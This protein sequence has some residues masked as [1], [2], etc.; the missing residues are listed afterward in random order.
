[1]SKIKKYL[2]I[3]FL[4]ASSKVSSKVITIRKKFSKTIILFEIIS[5]QQ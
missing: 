3:L 5:V 4:T 2:K 1:M